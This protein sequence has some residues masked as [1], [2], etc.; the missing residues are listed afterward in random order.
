MRGEA[1][2][3]HRRC[4]R[5]VVAD[6]SYHGKALRDLPATCTFT[7]YS[8]AVNET[9]GEPGDNV[10]TTVRHHLGN[11]GKASR[12]GHRSHP[13]TGGG[14]DRAVGQVAE[15]GVGHGG[16]VSDQVTVSR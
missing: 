15:V 9:S 16:E 14:V 8:V 1:A 13:G 2:E 3:K 11:T 6:A 10:R 7:T 12:Q 4:L 5:P